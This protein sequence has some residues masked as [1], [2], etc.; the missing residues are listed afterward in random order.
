MEASPFAENMNVDSF[1]NNIKISLRQDWHSSKCR[2][3]KNSLDINLKILLID[4]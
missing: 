4:P 2:K 1:D 3:N